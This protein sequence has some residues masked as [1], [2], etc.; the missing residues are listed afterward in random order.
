MDSKVLLRSPQRPL[1]GTFKQLWGRQTDCWA[2]R[3]GQHGT[4]AALSLGSSPDT[5]ASVCYGQEIPLRPMSDHITSLL[6]TAHWLPITHVTRSKI[7]A[8]VRQAPTEVLDGSGTDPEHPG[9]AWGQSGSSLSNRDLSSVERVADPKCTGWSSTTEKCPRPPWLSSTC[10]T[11]LQAK[12]Q[13]HLT[14]QT[15][16]FVLLRT[17]LKSIH[18]RGRIGGH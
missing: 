6:L 15:T 7:L 14:C 2:E 9:K 12:T 18:L 3:R 17:L 16:S 13:C 11:F 10:W 5:E 4:S 1:D 8:G